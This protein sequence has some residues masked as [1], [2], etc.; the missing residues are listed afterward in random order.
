ML[1]LF[2]STVYM[3]V[4][5]LIR[6]SMAPCGCRWTGGWASASFPGQRSTLISGCALPNHRFAWWSYLSRKMPVSLSKISA[7]C[8]AYSAT[9]FDRSPMGSMIE[10]PADEQP[11][12]RIWSR[13]SC[14]P[15]TRASMR[16]QHWLQ[17][18]RWVALIFLSTCA[19]TACPPSTN[20]C[21]CWL[22]CL[23]SWATHQTICGPQ[24]PQS[25]QSLT[26]STS[27]SIND[28]IAGTT[29]NLRPRKWRQRSGSCTS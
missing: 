9:T 29:K 7:R 26:Y 28:S 17:S 14:M 19:C 22:K 2:E 8:A 23:S 24:E 27:I 3:A 11:S 5:S 18:A 20:L 6:P 21:A 1:R 4:I 25:R 13:N 10:L 12:C 16:V 15:G